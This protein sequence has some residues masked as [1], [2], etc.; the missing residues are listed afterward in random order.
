M[1]GSSGREAKIARLQNILISETRAALDPQAYADLPP[2][3]AVLA[4]PL[5]QMRSMVRAGASVTK[6]FSLLHDDLIRKRLIPHQVLLRGPD[7]VPSPAAHAIALRD[8]LQGCGFS[9]EAAFLTQLVPTIENSPPKFVLRIVFP[10]I[11][12]M[13]RRKVYEPHADGISA[14]REARYI[15]L[16]RLNH[17]DP[18][19]YLS[20]FEATDPYIL[21]QLAFLDLAYSSV[22]MMAKLK[23]APAGD[24]RRAYLRFHRSFKYVGNRHEILHGLTV[25]HRA[26]AI[27]D[28]ILVNVL[29]LY[30]STVVISAYLSDLL[31]ANGNLRLSRDPQITPAM[32]SE[33]RKKMSAA[34]RQLGTL[35]SKP[36]TDAS[37]GSP[38]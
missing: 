5:L 13:F 8:H 28:N 4:R 25:E 11:E 23:N 33:L 27:S 15:I 35:I 37:A 10:E 17:A 16:G 20:I 3:L 34:L 22:D 14:F 32:T 36:N 19:D 12:E 30:A 38:D 6:L 24:G 18:N 29:T 31:A 21:T 9:L 26:D 7:V 2:L 1:S